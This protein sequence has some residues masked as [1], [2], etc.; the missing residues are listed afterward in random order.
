MYWYTINPTRIMYF[1]R[2]AVNYEN[3]EEDHENDNNIKQIL[4]IVIEVFAL[5]IILLFYCL[6][7]SLNITLIDHLQMSNSNR[8]NMTR[9]WSHSNLRPMP[10]HIAESYMKLSV[11]D[12][13][14][15]RYELRPRANTVI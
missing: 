1:L 15:C 2:G 4:Y 12:D 7:V 14:D 6:C 9:D 3:N 5:I 13:D 11:S 10:P 8:R